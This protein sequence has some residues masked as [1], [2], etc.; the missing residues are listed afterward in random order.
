[1]LH[2]CSSGTPASDLSTTVRPLSDVQIP[3]ADVEVRSKTSEP[4]STPV[5]ES[6]RV[7]VPSSM[8]QG[9]QASFLC[10]DSFYGTVKVYFK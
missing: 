5:K 4:S 10:G 1:M 6:V 9:N 3:P 7:S 2:K 8:R